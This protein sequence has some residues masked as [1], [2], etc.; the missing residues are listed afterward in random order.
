MDESTNGFGPGGGAS[1]A[2]ASGGGYG[3][4]G[5]QGPWG[6][7]PGGSTYGDSNAP[8]FPG[9]GAGGSSWGTYAGPGGN[10][11]GLIWIEA[12]KGTVTVKGMVSANGGQFVSYNGVAG[13]SGG[14]IYLT[15]KNLVGAADRV[16]SAV[17]GGGGYYGGGGG[18]GRIA[19]WAANTNDWLGTATAS[20]GL[21]TQDL[22]YP[23]STAGT[24][25]WGLIKLSGTSIIIY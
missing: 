3:G 13:G 23:L 2:F 11:G 15:C 12:P 5:G 18:G 9:S 4:V 20:R 24:V 1:Y 7:G 17:G 21:E 14:G 8:V 16:L 6:A 19:V 22:G 25:F 10:G